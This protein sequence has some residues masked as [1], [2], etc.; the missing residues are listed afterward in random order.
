M[1]LLLVGQQGIAHP[2]P[3]EE[4]VDFSVAPHLA[5]RED[6]PGHRGHGQ[7]GDHNA[8]HGCPQPRGPMFRA[9]AGERSGKRKVAS[10]THGQATRCVDSMAHLVCIAGAR[11]RRRPRQ[12]RSE[13]VVT[14]GGEI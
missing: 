3:Q 9:R 8:Q 10:T 14:A 11:H 7:E 13:T 12:H 2:E 6:A 5:K 4:F 1:H